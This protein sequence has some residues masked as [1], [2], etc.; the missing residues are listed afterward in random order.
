MTATAT[1][2]SIAAFN[3][4]ATPPQARRNTRIGGTSPNALVAS[5]LMAPSI[6]KG[7]MDALALPSRVG[8]ILHYRDSTTRLDP[9]PTQQPVNPYAAFNRG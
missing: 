2:T 6:R 7:S 5:D 4:K 3:R 1:A 8:N 9:I